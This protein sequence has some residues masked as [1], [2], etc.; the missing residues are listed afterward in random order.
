M[1]HRRGATINDATASFIVTL[2]ELRN[3]AQV[4]DVLAAIVVP[5]RAVESG[6]SM[7]H[8]FYSFHGGNEHAGWLNKATNPEPGGGETRANVVSTVL[9]V[10]KIARRDFDP[11]SF[12]RSNQLP[13]AHGYN[14][15]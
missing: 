3:F 8:P 14:S 5:M 1:M 4:G 10:L 7:G 2:Q 11:A 15:S 9:A 13:L 12:F 6:A